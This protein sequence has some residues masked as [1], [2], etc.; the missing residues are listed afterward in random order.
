MNLFILLLESEFSGHACLDFL[1]LR[2]FNQRQSKL[3]CWTTICLNFPKM[4]SFSLQRASISSYGL[5]QTRGTRASRLPAEL[6]SKLC[7]GCKVMKK[8]EF[9]DAFLL[10]WEYSNRFEWFLTLSIPLYYWY[11][12][13]DIVLI[14]K[15][16]RKRHS[17]GKNLLKFISIRTWW[18]IRSCTRR[19]LT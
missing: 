3:A 7:L 13:S 9:F 11:C 17:Y 2:E 15:V 19:Y 14:G 10:V 18:R 4:M 6:W 1:I 8:S 12:M 5:R 16:L